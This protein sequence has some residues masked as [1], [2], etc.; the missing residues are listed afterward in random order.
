MLEL[1]DPGP[2]FPSMARAYPVKKTSIINQSHDKKSWRITAVYQM[3][4][5][6]Y[7]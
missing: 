2:V 1:R 3:S 7:S 6:C 4:N 5:R